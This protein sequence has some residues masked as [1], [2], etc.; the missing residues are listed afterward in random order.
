MI[1]QTNVSQ[2]VIET[3]NVYNFLFT[4]RFGLS[5][6]TLHIAFDE[7]GMSNKE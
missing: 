7:K 3:E 2:V 1:T 5:T 4:T 6:S